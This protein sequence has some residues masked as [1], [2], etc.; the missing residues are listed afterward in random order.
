MVEMNSKMRIGVLIPARSGSKGIPHK[1]IKNYFGKPLMAH[2]I[3]LALKSKYVRSED[4]YVSTDSEEYQKI[5]TEYGAQA[6]F[7]RPTN[8]SGDLSTD[9]QCFQHF[10]N[11]LEENEKELPDILI[12]LRP[13][14]PNRSVELLDHLI[15]L[16]L[17]KKDEYDS[18]RTVIEIDMTPYKMYH[19]EEG[20]DGNQDLIPIFD[21]FGYVKE[22]FNQCRQIFPKT[23][24]HNGCIDIIKRET[25]EKG[26]MS[27]EYIYP[28]VMSKEE[29][30]DIDTEHDF[31][32]SEKSKKREE[33]NGRI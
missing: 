17:K 7:L 11:Y 10:L 20:E 13:T 5:A 4:V 21:R 30:H 8:I 26:M 28:Y 31:L 33:E 32:E 12:H 6:P 16:Y 27:G 15:E 18:L 9:I 2:S 14:Y 22:P 24:V 3:E 1:N 25:I 23:Y 19:I 29:R